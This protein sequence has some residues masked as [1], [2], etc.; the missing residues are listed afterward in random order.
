MEQ[1]FPGSIHLDTPFCTACPPQYYENR[2][3]QVQPGRAGTFQLHNLYNVP[4]SKKDSP[5]P[6]PKAEK[7]ENQAQKIAAEGAAFTKW[8]DQWDLEVIERRGPAAGGVPPVRH[9]AVR[10]IQAVYLLSCL[11]EQGMQAVGQGDRRP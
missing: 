1:A 3:T 11:D 6:A 4:C 8:C 7:G 9:C 5:S 2:A 10:R